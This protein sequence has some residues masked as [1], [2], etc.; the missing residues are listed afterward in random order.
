MNRR[1]SALTCILFLAFGGLAL[2][3]T[4][5]LSLSE[6]ESRLQEYRAELQDVSSRPDFAVN[7]RRQVPAEL[8]VQTSSG[9]VAVSMDFLH[10]GL[11]TYLV[12]D[13][14]FRA[15]ILTQLSDRLTALADEAA[16]Y[17]RAIASDASARKK[18]ETILSSY[19][20]RRVH[21]PTE[22]ELLQQRIKAWWEKLLRKISPHL[23]NVDQAGQ[24][25]VWVVIALASSVLAV[26]LYRR[27]RE[28]IMD[29]PREV[30][31]FVPSAKSWRVWLTE[32]RQHAAVGQWRDAIH[33]GFW[34]AVSRLEENGVWR[35]DKA[36]TPRE[37]LAAIPQE[38]E[39]R[40]SFAA[41]T[42]TFER[43]WYGGR[44]SSAADFESFLGELENLG[45]RA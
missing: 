40:S 36:R 33:L 27:S 28:R 43:A 32:A 24:V 19:E 23:D 17:D 20:F 26:W 18:L 44:P 37:Y 5:P 30:L 13:A 38:N 7:L 39:I 6:Y 4:A 21:G 15:E 35:P 29:H 8:D 9:V 31:P 41:V 10:K 2:C 16:N 22:W 11:D 25:F 34:A 42:R 12:T 14:K 1:Q 3:D 45:C